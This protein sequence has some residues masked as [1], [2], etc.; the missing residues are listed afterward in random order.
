MLRWEPW[1]LGG[2]PT[3][4]PPYP[5]PYP[6]H[7]PTLPHTFPT[8]ASWRERSVAA[9]TSAASPWTRRLRQSHLPPYD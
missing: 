5:T 9:P 7:Y 1:R 8:P 3:F 4:T 6:T 2:F